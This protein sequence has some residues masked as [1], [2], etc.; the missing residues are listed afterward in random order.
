MSDEVEVDFSWRTSSAGMAVGG[1]Q[2]V[3]TVSDT[4]EITTVHGAKVDTELKCYHNPAPKTLDD[5]G[6]LNVLVWNV[7]KQNRENLL[8][9]L[10]ERS[11]DRQLV[12]LQEASS[13][14]SFS[15]GY[16]AQNGAVTRLARSKPLMFRV[17]C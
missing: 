6:R 4:P 10:T 16:S 15:I 3:F 11:Q 17:V 14:I 2:A 12:L 1:F 8:S 5:E 7:Y 9:E 13:M